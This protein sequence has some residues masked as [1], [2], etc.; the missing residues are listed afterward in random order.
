MIYLGYYE[1][2]GKAKI[3]INENVSIPKNTWG[4]HAYMLQNDGI[5]IMYDNLQEIRSH[6]DVQIDRDIVPKMY[7]Y[8]I[9]PALCTQ[10]GI[11]SDIQ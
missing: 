10:S 6:I 7:T 2:R 1:R 8:C 11:K 5:K 9:S 3:K 4:T